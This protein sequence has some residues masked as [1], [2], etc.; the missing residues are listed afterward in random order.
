[1]A[2]SDVVTAVQARLAAG[3]SHCP[4]QADLNTGDR[5]PAAPF[6]T[7]LYPLSNAVQMSVGAPGANIWRE[8]GV[9]LL[10]LEVERGR[11]TSDYQPWADELAA[12]FRGK[13]FDGVQTFAP[14]S[15]PLG[16]DNEDGNFF[17]LSVAVPYQ[18]DLIG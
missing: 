18:F 10:V 4:V 3:W 2:H 7:V 1:M 5:L 13:N 12:L 6:L 11:G 9:F 8:E 16:D 14:T 15:S 17:K